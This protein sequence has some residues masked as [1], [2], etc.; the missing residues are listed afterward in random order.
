MV[1]SIIEYELRRLPPQAHPKT[2]LLDPEN[3]ERLLWEIQTCHRFV[4][5]EVR[6]GL[7]DALKTQDLSTLTEFCYPDRNLIFKR[8]DYIKGIRINYA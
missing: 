7:L 1:A 4:N 3:W 6:A 8:N 2:I 5:S